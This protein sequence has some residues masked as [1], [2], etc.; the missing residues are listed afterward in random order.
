MEEVEYIRAGRFVLIISRHVIN[1][2]SCETTLFLFNET[3]DLIRI[4]LNDFCEL[5]IVTS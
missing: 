5:L 1:C 3:L 2:T 4:M